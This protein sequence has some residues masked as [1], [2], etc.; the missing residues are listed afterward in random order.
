MAHDSGEEGTHFSAVDCAEWSR[1]WWK[2]FLGWNP[3]CLH[4]LMFNPCQ[5]C[6]SSSLGKR[7]W[8]SKL[9]VLPPSS[10]VKRCLFYW[11]AKGSSR[12]II[13]QTSS[14]ELV[15]ANCGFFSCPFP[16]PQFGAEHHVKQ[17]LE[18]QTTQMTTS[19]CHDRCKL[20]L[21]SCWS[22]SFLSSNQLPTWSVADAVF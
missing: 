2:Q 17:H 10:C 6:P 21:Q 19:S 13:C 5:N 11:F 9:P 7:G 4:I 1:H 15:S 12:W 18:W 20:L 14:R 16:S 3:H 22:V 8:A